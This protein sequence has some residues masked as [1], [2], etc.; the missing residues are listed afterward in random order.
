MEP[1]NGTKSAIL[2]SP[3]AISPS[4]ASKTPS[5]LWVEVSPA[6]RVSCEL[7]LG[8]RFSMQTGLRTLGATAS[9]AP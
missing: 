3:L 5:T 2:Y 1:R 7:R 8:L 6:T 9:G 4:S